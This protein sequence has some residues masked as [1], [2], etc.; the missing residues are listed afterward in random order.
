MSKEQEVMESTAPA[1]P[2]PSILVQADALSTASA[3][4]AGTS[5]VELEVRLHI[6]RDALPSWRFHAASRAVTRLQEAGLLINAIMSQEELVRSH[7][8]IINRISPIPKDESSSLQ[9]LFE[10]APIEFALAA[11]IREGSATLEDCI[12]ALAIRTDIEGSA[13]IRGAVETFAEVIARRDGLALNQI[14]AR[15]KRIDAELADM[16]HVHF[17]ITAESFGSKKSRIRRAIRLVDMAASQRLARTQL[18]PAWQS[19]LGKVEAVADE[20][21]DAARDGLRGTWAKLGKLVTYCHQRQIHPDNVND[22]TIGDLLAWLREGDFADAF[23]IVRNTVYAWETLQRNIPDFPQTPLTRLYSSARSGGNRDTLS[24]LPD[25][26]RAEWVAFERQ[27]GRGSERHSGSLANFVVSPVALSRSFAAWSASDQTTSLLSD[28][29]DDA[30]EEW[31][32]ELNLPELSDA[33]PIQGYA[34]GTLRNFKTC[35]V[36]AALAAREMGKAADTLLEILD[37]AIVSVA[38]R[39]TLAAQRVND[40]TRKNKN[41]TLRSC[42]SGFVSIAKRLGVR[43]DYIE[44]LEVLRDKVDPFL[45]KITKNADGTLKRHYDSQRMGMRHKG[46]LA[47][48]AND[49]A[50]LAWFDMPRN[51]FAALKRN[52]DLGKPFSPQLTNDAVVMV[53]HDLTRCSPTRRGNLAA[54]T[55]YG[56]NAWLRMPPGKGGKARLCI[57]REYVKNHVDIVVELTEQAVESVQFYLD[58]VRP[59]IAARVGADA[60]NPYLFPANGMNH[61]A[62]DSL[63]EEFVDRNW[64]L[65]GF[66]LN[67]HCQRHL[68]AKIILDHDPTQMETVR[69][70]LGHKTIQTTERYYAEIN[71]IF[72]QRQYHIHLEARYA[73]LC[74]KRNNKGKRRR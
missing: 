73:E 54:I 68:A 24:A 44:E 14:P 60:G 38:L 70:L 26:L 57:P 51:L 18:L 12:T 59:L 9:L 30:S 40:P 35:I 36:K 67:L 53:L 28:S 15:L 47:D 66:L 49:N 58:H 39:K 1:R 55:V 25:K 69:R 74:A 20:R 43:N 17:G 3:Q 65:G 21:Q 11:R 7:A 19:L 33:M 61:R 27:F 41:G 72:A 13:R 63:N 4:K 23:D 64:S 42:A 29:D 34:T 45:L 52:K 71:S 10:I 56:P 62:P 48:M 22:G 6:H 2:I 46:R 8:E 50:L 16:S 32:D 5:I 37:P 31:A